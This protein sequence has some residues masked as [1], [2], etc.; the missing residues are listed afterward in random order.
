M[1]T[2]ADRSL[3]AARESADAAW[4]VSAFDT[5]CVPA[6]VK[7]VFHLVAVVEQQQQQIAALQCRCNPPTHYFGSGTT[8]D[9]GECP[10]AF[11]SQQKEN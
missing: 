3:N 4:T 10:T 2:T 9:C 6:L 11:A 8:C 1:S 7:A 5:R